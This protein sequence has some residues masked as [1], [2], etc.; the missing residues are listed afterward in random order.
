MK[1]ILV[2]GCILILSSVAAF[3]DGGAAHQAAQ[4]A[5]V[6][7]GTSGGNILDRSNAF[8]CS[9]T[10]GALVTKGGLGYVLSNSHVLARVGQAVAG[11]DISQ[12]GLIDNGCRVPQIVADFSQGAPLNGSAGSNVDAALAQVR[13]GMVDPLGTIIDVGIPSAV[14]A[15]PTA[16]RGVAKSGR[17][18]GLTCG[19]IGSVNTSVNVQYQQG[20]GGGK[21]FTVSYTGQVVINSSTFSAGGDSGSL[22]VTSDSAQPVAL[23]YAGSSS[24]TIGNPIQQVASALGI[25]FVGAANHSVNCTGAALATSAAKS[26]GVSLAAMEHAANVKESHVDELMAIDAVQGVGV[27]QDD[28]GNAV[29]VVYTELGRP[30]GF[31]PDMIDGV[32]T[33]IVRTDV[34]RAFDWANEEIQ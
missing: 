20:C 26:R 23:L 7:L 22:I 9:G 14:L 15:T 32:K 8:C 3:A 21:K 25:T 28:A 29:I 1:S 13:V 27:G 30:E 11:E 17:T 10:L 5:P 4:A 24:S 2:P 6:K 33:K 19:S 18:T 16:G 34:F 31:I 12:P